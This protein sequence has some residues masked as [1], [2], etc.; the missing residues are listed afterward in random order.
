[1]FVSGLEVINKITL[2]NEKAYYCGLL[3]EC[4]KITFT[5]MLTR[6]RDPNPLI[7]SFVILKCI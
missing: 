3:C 2:L 5:A 7:T 4:Y 1:M 6:V